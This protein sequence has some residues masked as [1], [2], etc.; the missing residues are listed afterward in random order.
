MKLFT[1]LFSLISLIEVAG[2]FA[3]AGSHCVAAAA[4]T[5]GIAVFI[6]HHHRKESK[7]AI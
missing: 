7:K 6:S 3:G 4:I 5:A 1:L 2:F